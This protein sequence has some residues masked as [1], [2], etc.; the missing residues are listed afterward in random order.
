MLHNNLWTVTWKD[1]QLVFIFEYFKMVNSWFQMG[2][3]FHNLGAATCLIDLNQWYT[4]LHTPVSWILVLF[5]TFV[6]VYLI[7]SMPPPPSPPGG[8]VSR[9][10]F[11]LSLLV[12]L[13]AVH[14]QAQVQDLLDHLVLGSLLLHVL[15]DGANHIWGGGG[16]GEQWDII[17]L[18]AHDRL[19]FGKYMEIP[20]RRL[21]PLRCS[22]ESFWVFASWLWRHSHLSKCNQSFPLHDPSH[23]C[24][25]LFYIMAFVT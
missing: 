19:V 16:G 25:V 2:N 12:E 14:D 20:F 21:L 1:V 22:H 17:L 5:I 10:P 8:S 9:I 6:I 24:I 23:M 11:S 4:A 13:L 3:L 15:Y 18:V 7:I